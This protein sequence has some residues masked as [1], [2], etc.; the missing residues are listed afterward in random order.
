LRV[1]YAIAIVCATTACRHRPDA[2]SANGP[3]ADIVAQA[4]PNIERSVGLTFKRS[5]KL[6]T[7]SKAQ[8]RQFLLASISD[9][10]SQREMRGSQTAYKL[11]GLLPDTLDLQRLLVNLLTEQVV[12]FYDPKTKVLYVVD[13]APRDM[14][15]MTVTHELVHA[16]QDQ[17]INLDSIQSQHDN[18]RKTAAQ[19]VFEGEALYEQ[20]AANGISLDIPGGWNQVRDM[21]RQ[22]QASMPIFASAPPFIR[23]TL[24]FPYLDGAAFMKEYKARRGAAVPF[25]DMPQSTEQILHPDAYFTARDTP[26]TVT[27]ASSA[28]TARAPRGSA[29]TYVDDLGEFETSLWV[30]GAPAEH[31]SQRLADGWDG[32]RYVVLSTPRGDAL[33][34]AS[35][36]DSSAQ[37]QRVQ[38]ALQPRLTASP[39]RTRTL[40]AEQIQGRPVLLYTDVPRGVDPHLVMAGDI[41]LAVSPSPAVPPRS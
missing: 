36:W 37:A 30:Y 39:T 13:G 22:N 35:V 10:A 7:R 14:V 2:G 18:D 29:V 20:F 5:P 38:A 16:L 9:T 24:L 8:V 17:Y 28:L 41:R 1:A 34:W 26:T 3:Y 23:E 12:G 6:E 32:D 40:M 15:T 21:V 19:A 27:I 11:L 33:V 25:A 4:V 31:A